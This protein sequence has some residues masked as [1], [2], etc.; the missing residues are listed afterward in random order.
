[1]L[2]AGSLLKKTEELAE[3]ARHK[4]LDIKGV[5][6]TWLHDGIRE[7]EVCLPGYTLFSQDR[8]SH[9]KRRER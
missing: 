8:P 7:D 4:N 5:T 6:E 9:K 3:L 1:M 2:N